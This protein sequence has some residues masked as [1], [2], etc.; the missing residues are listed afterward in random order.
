MKTTQYIRQEKAI[1]SA[2]AGGI[3]ER[4]TWGLRLLR[5]PEAFAPGST[6]LKPGRAAELIKAAEAAGLKLSEREIRYR[7]QCARAYSTEAQILHACA[8][9]EDWSGLRSANFPTYETP[10]GEPLADHRTDDERKRDHAR[11]LIDIVG[12]QGALFPLSDFEPVTTTLKELDDYA[13]QQA[14]ITARFAA[15]DD[16]RR[17]YLDDLIAAAGDDLSVTWLAAHERLT[18]SS[19]VAS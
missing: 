12:D 9:F 8:E 14:E 13:R 19:E 11:A 15:H 16:R 7:L 4:W 17:A 1:A 10:D 18:G 5:D 3:R 2:D 6:Q